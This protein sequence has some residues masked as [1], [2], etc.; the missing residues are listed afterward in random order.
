MQ[1]LLRNYKTLH[2]DLINIL[3][4]FNVVGILQ[5]FLIT[6]YDNNNDNADDLEDDTASPFL[7]C[8]RPIG[9]KTRL[10]RPSVRPSVCP[11]RARNS[12]T[13]KRRK[14]KIGVHVPHGSSKWSVNF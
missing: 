1:Y 9:R 2:L 11:V 14:I 12:K 8:G 3:C 10:V 6:Y 4:F 5:Y 13:K 7:L